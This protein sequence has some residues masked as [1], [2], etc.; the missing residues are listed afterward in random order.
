MDGYFNEKEIDF[1][2]EQRSP[3]RFFLLWTRKEAQIKATSSSL[4]DG[5]NQ[6]DLLREIFGNIFRPLPARSCR[7]P[8]KM[9][10]IVQSIYDDRTFD[11]LPILGNALEEL[12][13]TDQAILD[14]CRQPGEHL[15]GCWVLDLLLGKD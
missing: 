3:D 12:G 13:V 10:A 8:L 15:R 7:L 9:T 5:L 2:N 6:C 4:V 14:H 11:S 1:I